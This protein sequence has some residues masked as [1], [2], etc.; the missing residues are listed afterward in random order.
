[1]LLGACGGKKPGGA[2]AGPTTYDTIDVEPA[3]AE[4]QV[5]L[6][7]TASQV[8]TV[9]G[10]VDGTQ[11][12]ITGSC[13]IGISSAF[14]T[15]SG[16][17]VTVGGHGGKSQV[18]AVCGAQT[19]TAELAIDLTGTVVTGTGT[20]P[21]A[22]DIFGAATLGADPTRDPAIEYPI[23]H[24]IAPR[25][26]P[27]I[28]VQ[29][30][31]AGNDLFHV[32]LTSTYAAIDVY[33]TD[34]Q[35]ALERVD[36]N[37]VTATAAGGSLVISVEGLAQA[38][39]D[40]RYGGAPISIVL[41]HD[42][43]N[44]TAIYYWASSQGNIMSQTFGSPDPPAL[45]KDDCTSCH[46]LSREGTRLGYSRCVANDCNQLYAGFM[47]YDP[48]MQAW[49]EPVNAND[50]AIHGSYTTF[51]PVGNPFPTDD[52]SLAIVSMANGTLSLYDPDSG[53]AVASN[54]DDVSTHGPGAPRSALMADWSADGTTVVY[55][56]T[57]HAN[58]WI[59]LSDGSIA[60]MSYTY[61][62]GAGTHT[63]G[64]PQFIVQGPIT[65]AGGD[66]TSFFFP[67]FSGDGQ[68]V[69]FDAARA[70]WRNFTDAKTAG[71]RL[72]LAA[73]DGSWITDLTA[74][75]GG[76]GDADITWPHWAP[77]DTSD[78]YWIVFSSERDYGHEVT[79]ANT[80]TSCV[81]NGVLQC[82]RSGSARSTRPRSRP[83]ARSIR[84]RRR[85]G[86]PAR[87]PR[88]TTSARTGPCRSRSTRAGPYFEASSMS[89]RRSWR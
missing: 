85:C 64:E 38:A 4:V 25:N 14:G 62:A 11:T 68:L 7:G 60:T 17:T 19:G 65:L 8:Y 56:S 89:T 32:S 46:S 54:L 1:M 71:Q 5:P 37:A 67:S 13:A 63:F 50:E 53:A 88:P 20:P 27:A 26:I 57:P 36:W 70:A 72:M 9:Y 80:A 33:T 35:A 82:S 15:V 42:T 86:S 81:R 10:V 48:S 58:Q 77:G 43:V 12:D 34:L 6:G 2:D 24:A 23:D 3:T 45:V 78:Y 28:E 66:Y 29:W 16:A 73:A 47:R 83:A 59:D 51:A 41:S 79:A 87:I 18:T 31:A 30:T 22:P 61:D 40:T 21:D 39:P 69:V 74:L 44:M 55:A 84:A 75:D 76:T 49:T 52:Q